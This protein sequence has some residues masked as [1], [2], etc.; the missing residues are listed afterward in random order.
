MKTSTVLA[1]VSSFAALALAAPAMQPRSNVDYTEHWVD[2]ADSAV[3]FGPSA[4]DWTPIHVEGYF[5]N[6]ETYS[7]STAAYWEWEYPANS[8]SIEIRCAKKNDRGRFK[9]EYNG[10]YIGEGDAHGDCTGEGCPTS[11]V[12]QADLKGAARASV[13][14][15]SSIE[16]D[17]LEGGNILALDAIVYHQPPQ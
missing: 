4:S 12:F 16:D 9:V 5:Y 8:Y 1:A 13:L 3:V 6:T 17:R 7:R 15:V 2:N 10:Q 11:V 14:K